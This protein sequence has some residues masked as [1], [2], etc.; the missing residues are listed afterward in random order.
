MRAWR[1]GSRR[2]TGD[3][4]Q[5]E[6]L[7]IWAP[8]SRGRL[9]RQ[10]LSGVGLV[11]VCLGP[12]FIVLPAEDEDENP[13]CGAPA[14]A[15]ALGAGTADPGYEE[16]CRT[17]ARASVAFGLILTLPGALLVWWQLRWRRV[18]VVDAP[19]PPGSPAGVESNWWAW[20]P[21]DA[22]PVDLY[23]RPQKA[24]GLLLLAALQFYL[25][26]LAWVDARAARLGLQRRPVLTLDDTGLT[27][28][29]YGIALPWSLVRS[30]RLVRG[31]A[32]H[33]AVEVGGFRPRPGWRPGAVMRW[34]A[35]RWKSMG[36]RGELRLSVWG[37][38]GV[39]AFVREAS[40]RVRPRT[41]QSPDGKEPG[42]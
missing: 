12:L 6:R 20:P 30:V 18:Q 27:D 42:A 34:L 9:R 25:P 13:T 15:V 2:S 26:F 5:R 37:L 14:I 23:L 17:T 19:P 11:L 4:T 21:S 31:T 24:V 41:G 32:E 22:R 28:H 16:W 36:G 10:I 29:R 40:A 3:R 33:V 39:E 8:T 1:T 38:E 7:P 35:L